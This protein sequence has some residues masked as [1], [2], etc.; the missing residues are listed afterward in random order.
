[1][2]GENHEHHVE[3]ITRRNVTRDLYDWLN[4]TADVFA[5]ISDCKW[6][7]VGLFG[8]RNES[9]YFNYFIIVSFR[10]IISKNE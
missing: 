7:S 3:E 8:L 5:C 6:K 1:M 9:F 4:K 2:V 10:N